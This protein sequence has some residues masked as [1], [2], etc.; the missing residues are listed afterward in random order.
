MAGDVETSF[1]RAFGLGVP[2]IQGPMGGVAGVRLVTA[3]CAAGALGVL[4]IWYL[5]PDDA[6]GAVAAVKG[7]TTRPFAVNV[8]AD[9]AQHDLVAAALAAGAPVVHLFWGDAG[10]YAKAIRAAGAK[11]IV[12]VSDAA[13]A[14]A[15]LEAGADGL[16]AQGVEAGGHVFGETSLADLVPLVVGMAGDIPVAAAGG[17]V[18]AADAARARALG[19]SAVLLGTALAAT[20]ESDAHDAYKQALVDAGD[21]ATVRS[22][23]FDGDWPDAPHRTLANSTY[24]AW[25]E[26]GRPAPGAR[27]GEGDV[28]LSVPGVMELARYHMIT[29]FVGLEG[30]VEAAAM[31]A[32]MGVGK[33]RAVRRA[34]DVIAEVAAGIAGAG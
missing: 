27:P 31:Y 16:I 14:K 25:D 21:E 30:E 8:R 4:P 1:T 17:I 28:V 34:G 33:V 9:L 6:K 3:A 24:R 20:E 10:P 13:T 29:P 19:A 11:L 18:E 7:V 32:G 22:T 5:A 26:A 2:V 23:C 12:T 15:A